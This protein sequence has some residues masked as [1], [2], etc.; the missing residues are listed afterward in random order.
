M[1]FIILVILFGASWLFYRDRRYL[2]TNLRDTVSTEM[3]SL[4]N[5]PTGQE[6]F[7]HELHQKQTQKKMSRQI[8]ENITKENGDF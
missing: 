1:V 4:L 6:K 3:K 7:P 2:K 8:L 5:I